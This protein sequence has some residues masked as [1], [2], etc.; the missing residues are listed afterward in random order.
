MHAGEKFKYRL[1]EKSNDSCHRKYCEDV[2]FYCLKGK[3]VE[4]L[5]FFLKRQIATYSLSF[6]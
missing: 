5:F 3:I 1:G 2:F 6:E 4:G